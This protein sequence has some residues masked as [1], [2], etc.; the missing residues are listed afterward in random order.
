MSNTNISI[1]KAKLK[2]D[3]YNKNLWYVGFYHGFNNLGEGCYLSTQAWGNAHH[4][5]D[6][7]SMVEICRCTPSQAKYRLRELMDKYHLKKDTSCALCGRDT[8][9]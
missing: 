5:V 8:L 1:Y 9:E 3:K 6:E 7:E 2:T 4:E